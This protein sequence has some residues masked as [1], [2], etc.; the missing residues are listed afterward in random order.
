L[1]LNN[2]QDEEFADINPDTRMIEE[3]SDWYEQMEEQQEEF[4]LIV[5]SD[6]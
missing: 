1:V 6:A 5:D 4:D 3:D 2:L